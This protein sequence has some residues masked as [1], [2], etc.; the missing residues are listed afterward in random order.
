MKRFC[1]VPPR[2]LPRCNNSKLIFQ[3]LKNQLTMA[4]K[5][6]GV[7]ILLTLGLASGLHAQFEGILE[8]KVVATSA[9]SVQTAIYRLQIG[10]KNVAAEFHESD[11][12]KANGKFIFRGDKNV[13]WIVD[14]DQK[15]Y[16]EISTARQ[17]DGDSANPQLPAEKFEKLQRTGKQQTILGYPCD[18]LVTHEQG[19]EVRILATSKLGDIY[20]GLSRSLGE[21]GGKQ[22]GESGGWE[23]Q[24]A[25]LKMFPLRV[26]TTHDSHTSETQEVT[27]I[28]AATIDPSVFLPPAGYR[29][30]SF[31][32]NMEKMLEQMKKE[33]ESDSSGDTTR[34]R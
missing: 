4:A 33:A 7:I 3:K 23:H 16:I 25:A 19:A 26:T 11:V 14:D 6:S 27:Q 24:L 2:G 10:G 13:L 5:V 15:N 22:E 9:D 21:L 34:N 32:L 31:D 20:E 28:T 17:K 12:S 29:K 30:E 8:M 1:R 18:E